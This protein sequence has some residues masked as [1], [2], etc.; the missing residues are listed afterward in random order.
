MN[1]IT[2]FFIAHAENEEISNM[3]ESTV[4]VSASSFSS[5]KEETANTWPSCWTLKQ[6]NEFCEKNVYVQK[7]EKLVV[8]PTVKFKLLESRQKWV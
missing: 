2:D 3:S 7:A 8:V 5:A 4:A 6:K 1:K